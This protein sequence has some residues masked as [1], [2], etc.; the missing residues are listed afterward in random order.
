[1]S[2]DDAVK[3]GLRA[4]KDLHGS[5]DAE[6]AR[7]QADLEAA[8]KERN[9]FYGQIARWPRKMWSMRAYAAAELR[10]DR[11]QYARQQVEAFRERVEEAL[12]E[13]PDE[14]FDGETYRQECVAAIRALEP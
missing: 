9:E 4:D 12:P 10:R 11:E 6:I 3:S 2:L 8:H 1:M 7:L 5:C 14:D 13:V